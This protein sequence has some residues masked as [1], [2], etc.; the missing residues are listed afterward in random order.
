MQ[1]NKIALN[2]LIGLLLLFLLI[3]RSS[4]WIALKNQLIK[5]SC[6]KLVFLF[7]LTQTI[8]AILNQEYNKLIKTE[9]VQF[10]KKKYPWAY[11][12]PKKWNLA[13]S[14]KFW[15]M[16]QRKWYDNKL[17]PNIFFLWK[18]GLSGKEIIIEKRNKLSSIQFA[19]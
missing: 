4:S 17:T 10:L 19:L 7:F 5:K 2:F 1:G 18:W 8:N 9:I 11:I 13:N 6:H 16:T 15:T 12:Q 3:L 14:S